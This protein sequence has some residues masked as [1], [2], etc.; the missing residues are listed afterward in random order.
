MLLCCLKTNKKVSSRIAPL[1]EG[2][3]WNNLV[4]L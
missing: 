4:S 1:S 3:Q 2:M